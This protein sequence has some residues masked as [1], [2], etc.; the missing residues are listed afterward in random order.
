LHWGCM[1]WIFPSL[2]R[3]WLKQ[4]PEHL[5]T[6]VLVLTDC[7]PKPSEIRHW[8]NVLRKGYNEKGQFSMKK[9]QPRN[10]VSSLT[11]IYL[12]LF[13]VWTRVVFQL[14][15]RGFCFSDFSS[16]RSFWWCSFTRSP[17]V[18]LMTQW[19][20]KFSH[21]YCIWNTQFSLLY[22]IKEIC[23]VEVSLICDTY[24]LKRGERSGTIQAKPS[25]SML[26]SHVSTTWRFFCLLQFLNFKNTEILKKISNTIN[27]KKIEPSQQLLYNNMPNTV[28]V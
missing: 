21:P 26:L 4:F 2:C 1:N 13:Y 12:D 11:Y 27:T 8:E 15:C 18:V 28:V 3:W 19:N 16:R 17:Y 5:E 25:F 10:S 23:L 7:C 9:S 22:V 6:R 14:I 20:I 24:T